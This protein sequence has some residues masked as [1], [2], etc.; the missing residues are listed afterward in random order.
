MAKKKAEKT[1]PD[2]LTERDIRTMLFRNS[3]LSKAEKI[4]LKRKLAAEK[5]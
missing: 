5:A 2:K 1:K 3:P 4:E